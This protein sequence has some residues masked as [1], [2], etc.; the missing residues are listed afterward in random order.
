MV[1][2]GT[3]NL[4][5]AGKQNLGWARDS[6]KKHL[7]LHTCRHTFAKRI[8]SGYY[9]GESA[10]IETLAGLMGNTPKVCW[11][12]YAQWCDE[13]NEPLWAAVGR[14]EEQLQAREYR[15]SAR[16]RWPKSVDHAPMA[17]NPSSVECWLTTSR[18]EPV[19]KKRKTAKKTSTKSPQSRTTTKSANRTKKSSAHRNGATKNGQ[20][21]KLLGL[22]EWRGHTPQQVAWEVH[23]GDV[24]AVLPTLQDGRFACVVTSPP[25]YWQR[26]YDVEGQI[27]QEST[28]D[29]Y[30]NA[31]ADTMDGVRKVLADDGCVF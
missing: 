11:D 23:C 17:N 12:Q 20:F 24:N 9:T 28:I 19:A 26:D 5:I 21:S 15:L 2:R 1:L 29:G 22:H 6:D 8:L 3:A 25:Y 10:S 31:I 18:R 14:A 16:S 27:G 7:S 30:V 13:Y 4:M